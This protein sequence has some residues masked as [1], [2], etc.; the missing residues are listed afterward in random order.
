MAY[1]GL[2]L[3]LDGNP[4]SFAGTNPWT[5]GA[6]N[7]IFIGEAISAA[8]KIEYSVIRSVSKITVTKS[9]RQLRLESPHGS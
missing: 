5:I 3:E 2:A 7:E 9:S 6:T 8:L 1:N 4:Y